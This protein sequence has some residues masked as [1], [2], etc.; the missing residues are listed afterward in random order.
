[1]LQLLRLA[2][3]AAPIAGSAGPCNITQQLLIA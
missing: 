2:A 3:M 1:V